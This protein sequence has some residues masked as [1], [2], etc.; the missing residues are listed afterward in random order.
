M[1]R[2]MLN[3]MRKACHMAMVVIEEGMNNPVPTVN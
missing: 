3:S 1:I 2:E